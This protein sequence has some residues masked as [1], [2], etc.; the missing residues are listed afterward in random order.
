MIETLLASRLTT[1]T[2][3][4]S[5]VS[6]IVVDRVGAASALTAIAAGGMAATAANNVMRP[7]DAASL[8]QAR[9]LQDGDIREFFM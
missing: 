6:A 5:E 3:V 4:S 9:Q 8:L 2:R 1:T 7:S